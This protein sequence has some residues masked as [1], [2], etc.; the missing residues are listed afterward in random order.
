MPVLRSLAVASVLVATAAL[1]GCA[2]QGEMGSV[3]SRLGELEKSVQAI[4]Q[5]LDSMMD[6]NKM[7]A[8]KAARDAADA[9]R[10]AEAAAASSAKVEEAFRKSLRK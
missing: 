3:N 10:A 5:R 7:A 1:G 6:H 2:S 4:N 8:E 9:K